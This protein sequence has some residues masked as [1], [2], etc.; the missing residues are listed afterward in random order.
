MRPVQISETAQKGR[1]Q[2]QSAKKRTSV[3][4]TLN[5]MDLTSI[6]ARPACQFDTF[7]HL[8]CPHELMT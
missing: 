1:M 8:Y 6:F 2:L 7:V 5:E 4:A 3:T